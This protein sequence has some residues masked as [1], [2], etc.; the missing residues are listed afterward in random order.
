MLVALDQS[1]WVDG[2][3]LDAC[4]LVLA[5]EIGACGSMGMGFDACGSALAV[6]IGACGLTGT[7]LCMCICHCGSVLVAEMDAWRRF[8]GRTQVE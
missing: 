4:G 7:S 1:S 8:K 2:N 3:G 6:E 5:V